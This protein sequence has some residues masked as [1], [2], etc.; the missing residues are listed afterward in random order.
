MGA[1]WDQVPPMSAFPKSMTF[2]PWNRTVER[3]S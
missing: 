3:T 1:G 2:P